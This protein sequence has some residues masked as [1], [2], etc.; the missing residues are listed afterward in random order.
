MIPVLL[1]GVFLRGKFSLSNSAIK[2]P[3]NW[4]YC[5]LYFFIYIGLIAYIPKNVVIHQEKSVIYYII[6]VFLMAFFI[7]GDFFFRKIKITY[8][9]YKVLIQKGKK[10]D[11]YAK[12][13]NDLAKK[14][15]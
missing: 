10:Y 3:L 11:E 8:F 7:L 4:L 1:I 2:E 13:L 6:G 9:K 5:F 15:H 12:R 14:F